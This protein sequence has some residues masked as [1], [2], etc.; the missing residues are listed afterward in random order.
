VDWKRIE[1]GLKAQSVEDRMPDAEEFR[2]D[3]K[4]HLALVQQEPAVASRPRYAMWGLAAATAA[5]MLALVVFL[6]PPT[7]APMAATTEVASLSVDV[8]HGSVMILDDESQDATIV[9]ITDMAVAE[10]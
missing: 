1:Q 10:L 9:W 5:A 7:A 8:D 3:A 6:R 2:A 4:A